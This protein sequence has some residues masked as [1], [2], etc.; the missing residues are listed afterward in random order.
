MDHRGV[1]PAKAASGSS[2]S[3]VRVD[4]RVV[5]GLIA[6]GAVATVALWWR[7]TPSVHGFG[8]W[9][10]NAG[11]LT[12]LWAG[13]GVVVLVALMARLPPLER[14]IGADRLA[15]WHAMGGRYTVGLIVAHALLITWGYAV[16]AHTGVVSQA[17]SLLNSY[18]DVLMASAGGLLFVGVGIVSARAAR[19]RMRYET[20]YYLHFYT[21]LAIALAFSHQFAVGAQFISSLPARVFW[22]AL[23]L[24]VT[25]AVVWYRILTPVRQAYRHKLRVV[26]VRAEGPGVVSVLIAGWHLDELRA[27]SGQFFRWRFLTRDLWWTSSPYSLS[28][29]PAPDV[30]R[31]TVK[32]IGGHSAALARLRPGTRVLAEGPYGALTAA[33]RRRRRVLLIAGGVGITPLRALF[34]SLPAAPG[35]LTL[36]YRVSSM[37]DAVLRHEL[38][39]LAEQRGARAWFVTGTRAS[40][41]GDPLTAAA[42]AK[43]VPGLTKHDVYLCGPPGL[44][45]SVIGELRAAGVRRH[46]IHHESFEF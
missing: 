7:G 1:S 17:A 20:W 28:A 41:G 10:T 4:P 31:I 5:Q 18:P 25:A 39:R 34:E 23:Y 40:L 21:Y 44:T 6:A 22:S 8:D 15:R 27:E 32:A 3:P 2:R 12:G 42:L 9:L 14:G 26:R 24:A 33:K 19:R 46:Q 11:R 35:D 37:D 38:E 13:Y 45:G 29:P 30:L 36:I 16:T 43:R